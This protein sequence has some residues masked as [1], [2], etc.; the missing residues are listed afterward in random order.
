MVMPENS[1]RSGV[2]LRDGGIGSAL[3]RIDQYELLSELGGGG[4]GTVY[5]ARDTVSGVRYAVKGLPPFVK[6]NREEL[7]N[8]KAN[9]ALVSRLSHTNI[10]RAH[11]LHLAKEVEYNS[12]EVHRKLR[13]DTGDTLMVMEYAPGVTLSQWRKQFPDRKVPLGKALEVARQIASALDYAH[14]KKILHRDVKPANVMVETLE[15]GSL[16]ARVLDFGLAAEIRSSMGHVSR[17]IHDTSGTRPYMAPEQWVGAKQGPATDQYALAALFCELVTGDVPFASVFETDDTMVMLNAVRGEPYV[18]PPDL[19][20]AMR[21][22][23]VRALAKKP[24]RRFASC[25]A[26]ANALGGTGLRWRRLVF[27]MF[28]LLALGAAVYWLCGLDFGARRRNEAQ[29]LKDAAVELRERARLAHEDAN[30]RGFASDAALSRQ[31]REFE[32]YYRA[33]MA[34]YDDG[35]YA[36]ATNFFER[37]GEGMRQMA[38]EKRRLDAMQANRELDSRNAKEETRRLTRQ[39]IDACKNRRY[40]DA[41]R[42]MNSVDRDDA[43]VQF[44]LGTMYENGQGV[45]KDETEAVKWYRKAAEQGNADAQYSLGLMYKIGRGVVENE[46]E[47]QVWYRKALNQYREVA[48]QGNAE[49]QTRV[50]KCYYYGNGVAKD[51]VEAV[52]WYRKAAEQGYAEAQMR[53]GVCYY[54][55]RGVEKDLDAYVKWYR[56]AAEQGNVDAQFRLGTVYESGD[57]VE[58]DEAEAFKWYRKAAEQ[59]HA[60]AQCNLGFMYENGSGVTKDY[61]EAVKWYHKAA[62]Q[63]NG[64]GEFNLGDMYEYGKGVEKDKAEAIKWYHKAAEHGHPKAKEKLEALAAERNSD[65]VPVDPN[66]GESRSAESYCSTY[67]FKDGNTPVVVSVA[68]G[69]NPGRLMRTEELKGLGDYKDTPGIV[70]RMLVEND[71]RGGYDAERG[72]VVGIGTWRFY[73]DKEVSNVLDC[74]FADSPDDDFEMKRFKAMWKAY[75]RALADIARIKGRCTLSAK[76][77]ETEPDSEPDANATS[78]FT[79][80]IASM[81]LDGVT[82][83]VMAESWAEGRYEVSVAMCQSTKRM[84]AYSCRSTG[85][86]ACPGRYSIFERLEC[87]SKTGMICPQSYCDKDG[88]WWCI[89]GVPVGLDG[90]HLKLLKDSTEEAKCYAYEAALRTIAVQVSLETRVTSSMVEEPGEVIRERFRGH[91]KI[92]P[93]VK[94]PPHPFRTTEMIDPLTGKSIHLAVAFLPVNK[95]RMQSP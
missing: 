79:E 52:K 92:D 33:G 31:Y 27:S 19:P 81:Q 16:V 82:F 77:S 46:G 95:G 44:Y 8:V 29:R 32:R 60:G 56:K 3:A 68:W 86:G 18:P 2:T 51:Y 83:L 22:A 78:V 42:V 53:L 59:G 70:Y 6:G 4:F 20:K 55:G 35:N 5:L 75:A 73:A 23:L 43:E 91:I 40:V 15:D 71:I 54:R 24:G 10:A 45:A 64:S 36:S 84:E 57:G 11:V 48:E 30:R 93:V 72:R 25:T 90:K 34:S 61:A 39:F 28:A 74:G 17:E 62:E 76:I 9:F 49:V 38:A 65:P 89:A 66:G 69:V 58:K 88:V 63:G 13:V 21:A 12:E 50:G 14:A 26:F 85:S 37:A 67:R 41:V 87:V 1:M 7:E 80:S 94:I 47:A